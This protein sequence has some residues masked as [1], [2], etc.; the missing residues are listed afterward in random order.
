[1]S[2]VKMTKWTRVLLYVLSAYIVVLFVLILVKF[3]QVI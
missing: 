1:M 2:P 3:V